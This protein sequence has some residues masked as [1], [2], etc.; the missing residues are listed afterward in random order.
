MKINHLKQD[1]TNVTHKYDQFMA[2]ID[3]FM[4]NSSQKLTTVTTVI[5]HIIILSCYTCHV[6]DWKTSPVWYNI[7]SSVNETIHS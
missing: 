3:I 1:R 7:R 2:K 4:A 5:K 6:V